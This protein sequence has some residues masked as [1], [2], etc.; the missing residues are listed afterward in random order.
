MKQGEKTGNMASNF[1]TSMNNRNKNN[2]W[3][4]LTPNTEKKNVCCARFL[5]SIV[6]ECTVFIICAFFIAIIGNIATIILYNQSL[7][8]AS[9]SPVIGI[10]IFLNNTNYTLDQYHQTKSE[11]PIAQAIPL[12]ERENGNRPEKTLFAHKAVWNETSLDEVI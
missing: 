10:K 8:N 12:G 3:L 11:H 7:S 2:F 4:C 6:F 5:P 9:P 1:K